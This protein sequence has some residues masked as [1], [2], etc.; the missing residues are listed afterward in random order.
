[1]QT[2]FGDQSTSLSWNTLEPAMHP[3]RHAAPSRLYFGLRNNQGPAR[4]LPLQD[5]LNRIAQ[6]IEGDRPDQTL[7]AIGLPFAGKLLPDPEPQVHRALHRI[8]AQELD[9]PEDEEEDAGGDR[10]AADSAT[11]PVASIP[12]MWGYFRV[13]PGFPVA[14][15]ASL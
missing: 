5:D 12:G 11:V 2:S 6:A 13:T 1:M 14:E 15:S 10:P 9:P 7:Q 4:A 8:G 3:S